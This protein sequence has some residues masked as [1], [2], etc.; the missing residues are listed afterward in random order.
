MELEDLE[1]SKEV[2]KLVFEKSPIGFFFYGKDLR[3]IGFNNKFLEILKGD[4]DKIRGFDLNLINDNRIL[5]ALR[6][7]LSGN[8]GLYEGDYTTTTSEFNVVWLHLRTSAVLNENGEILFIVGMLED[9]TERKKAENQLRESEENFKYLVENLNDVVYSVDTFG[10]FTYVSP[11]IKK[12]SG[13][14]QSEVLGHS[15]LG[16]VNPIDLP[17]L[18]L[19]FKEVI[20][21]GTPFTPPFRIKSKDGREVYIQT[22]S[23]PTVKNGK[24]VG[25]NGLMID[26]TEKKMAEDEM[27]KKTEE[28]E[29]TNKLMVGRELKMIEMKKKMREAGIDAF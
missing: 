13:Y 3:V 19:R 26:V 29:K 4:G 25:I 2:Y 24:I 17:G 9:L 11:M 15:F 8:D 12:I 23:R 7:P 5:P 20:S 18:L 28:L 27:R 16:F 1:K 6:E 14:E 22:R 21:S 10:T